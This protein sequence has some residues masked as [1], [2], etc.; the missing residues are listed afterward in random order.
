MYECAPLT[1]FHATETLVPDAA[2]MVMCGGLML[3]DAVILVVQLSVDPW[4]VY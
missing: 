2:A 3:L 1:G 4:A